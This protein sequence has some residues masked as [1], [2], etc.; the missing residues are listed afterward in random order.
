MFMKE[1]IFNVIFLLLI[2]DQLQDST[3][4]IEINSESIGI[5]KWKSQLKLLPS[6]LSALEYHPPPP[7]LRHL[8]QKHPL[9]FF[10]KPLPSPLLNPQTA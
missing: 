7:P 5:S 8:P 3:F 2:A 1:I 4:F 9:I 6:L 10:I